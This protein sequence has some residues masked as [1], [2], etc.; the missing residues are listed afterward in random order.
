MPPPARPSGRRRRLGTGNDEDV[1]VVLDVFGVAKDGDEEDGEDCCLGI[2]FFGGSFVFIGGC[3]PVRNG[4]GG[5][6][7]CGVGKRYVIK[8]AENSGD[9]GLDSNELSHV[10][11]IYMYCLPCG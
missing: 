3:F 5:M 6:D 4:S 1:V 8:L 9:L 10:Q 2:G 7:L 11:L